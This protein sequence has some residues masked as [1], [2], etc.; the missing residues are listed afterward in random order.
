[1]G[2]QKVQPQL[3]DFFPGFPRLE[4]FFFQLEKNPSP[5]TSDAGSQV[6]G[7]RE[8][9]LILTSSSAVISAK[10]AFDSS[11]VYPSSAR[12]SRMCS[13]RTVSSKLCSKPFGGGTL[14]NLKS[15]FSTAESGFEKTRHS[16][17]L[18]SGAE[19]SSCSEPDL[20]AS[21]A[22]HISESLKSEK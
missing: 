6:G 18:M 14:R 11:R 22:S 8:I 10:S 3:L 19:P 20:L 15:R 1:M 5:R 9:G 7:V 21:I 2:L 12:T 4:S 16:G 17:S 13:T